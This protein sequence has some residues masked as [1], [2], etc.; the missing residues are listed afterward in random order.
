MPGAISRR[1]YPAGIPQKRTPAKQDSTRG[2]S[3]RPVSRGKKP[4]GCGEN[5]STKHVGAGRSRVSETAIV[6]VR[7]RVSAGEQLTPPPRFDARDFGLPIAG[8]VNK[9]GQGISIYRPVLVVSYQYRPLISVVCGVRRVSYECALVV[10]GYFASTF[11]IWHIWSRL[12]HCR[13]DGVY[14]TAKG[15]TCTSIYQMLAKFNW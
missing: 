4:D 10:S 2:H 8:T 3:R 6:A 15:R 13:Q 12:R 7:S 9:G 14:A 11:A 5:R 1:H